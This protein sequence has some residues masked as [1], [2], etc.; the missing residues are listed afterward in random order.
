[1]RLTRLGLSVL[2]AAALTAFDGFVAGNNLLTLVAV[3]LLAALFVA[4][5]QVRYGPGGLEIDFVFPDQVFQDAP[6]L[7]SIEARN[8]KRRALYQ[9]AVAGPWGRAEF[10]VIPGRGS[11]RAEMS[12]VF[13]RRGLTRADDLVVEGIHPF[14]FFRYRRPLE[15]LVVTVLPAL[16]EI[17]GRP[18]SPA[19]RRDAVAVPRR[20]RGDEFFGVREYAPGEDARLIHWKLTARTG[21]PLVLE[22]AQ[23]IGDRVTITADGTP[24]P[25]TEER[26]SEAA[27]L[28]RFFIDAG[29]DVRLRTNEGEIPYGKGLQH[30]QSILEELAL[31]GEG[32]DVHSAPGKIPI[33]PRPEAPAA[34]S[35]SASL[36]AAAAAAIASL[37]LVEEIAP[38]FTA[39]S[40]LIL[41][42][43]WLFDKRN[44]HPV[45]KWFFEAGALVVLLL[46][47][48][49]GLPAA[50]LIPTI[51][52][53]LVYV[54]TAYLWSPK[55]A[56]IRNRLLLGLF[57]LFVLA[58]SQAVDLWYAP[59][60]A[61]FFLA[62]GGWLARWHDPPFLSGPKPGRRRGVAAVGG[63]VL[64]VSALLFVLLPRAYGPSMQQF[65]AATGLSRFQSPRSSFA[66]LSDQVD[67]G[68]FGPLRK[69][70]ARAMQVRFVD[71]PADFRRPEFLRVRAGAFDR[72]TGRRWTR[73]GG[74][75]RVRDGTRFFKSRNG[76][77]IIRNRDGLIAFPGYDSEGP[78]S[79]LE[80]L[81]FPMIGS[82]VF[83][84]GSIG[85]LE[86]GARSAAFDLNDTTTF[87]FLFG[88]QIRYRIRV[89]AE[90]APDG[91][92]RES[93]VPAYGDAVEGYET[94]LKTRFLD[95]AGTGARWKAEAERM[96]IRANTPGERAAA[97]ETWFRTRFAYSLTAARNRQDMDAFLWTTRA[98]N[99][100]YFA[101]AMALLLRHLGIP[102]RLAVGFLA[103][104]WNAFGGFFN[105]RQSDAHAW[106]E[107]Y[108][109][110]RGWTTFDPTPADVLDREGR[111]WPAVV[112]GRLRRGLD[113]VESRWYR[114]VVGYDTDTR[115]TFFRLL[116]RGFSRILVPIGGAAF[117][118]AILA[119]A[120]GKG[121]LLQRWRFR[122]RR[123]IRREHFYYRVL[124]G[125]ER[126]G[127]P[128][129]PGQTAGDW[130]AEVVRRRPDFAV[131]TGLT[132]TFYAVRYAGARLTD[133]EERR[134]A[135]DADAV[136][137]ALRGPSR[138]AKKTPLF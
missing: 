41:P 133:A 29:A 85:A 137:R 96:T 34:N 112:W 126:A 88:A 110:D 16:F 53:I 117:L 105:V 64:L 121:K 77:Y 38:F 11:V 7:L 3:V 22:Y 124:D 61:A 103:A 91:P 28:A 65:L 108:L 37:W 71:P 129:S 23:T 120:V 30:L 116:D 75:F 70:P 43:G 18:A 5:I 87:P 27:S 132:E 73:S 13:R 109:P 114:Y 95:P 115:I 78:A 99:C 58:S 93:A 111:S 55:T 101:T 119:F 40:A 89:P 81:V 39:L 97:M 6:C 42:V 9:M 72:F 92:R 10:P 48:L 63:R 80:F 20:G 100:E 90:R 76:L 106:V 19:V 54:V 104:E 122:K 26:I 127:F 131:L 33:P 113:A 51:G 36:Y 128:R 52:A 8:P 135:S 102:S 49:V 2:A 14:G 123:R 62:A 15:G 98:G 125:L 31:L 44:R 134:A 12:H 130:A 136:L 82:T 138:S 45:P 86:T 60:F 83:S 35:P 21:R 74:D 32:K 68:F 67:L 84:A 107:A 24:G 50:G 25:G 1:M 118:I 17:Y 66:G 94:I 46:A 47:F 79:R 4:F 56:L 69:N 57:L 59:V